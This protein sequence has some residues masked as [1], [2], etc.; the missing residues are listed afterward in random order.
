MGMDNQSAVNHSG[1]SDVDVNITIDTT[2]LAYAYACYMHASGK[3]SDEEFDRM[4]RK[5]DKLLEKNK[6]ISS[7]D[8]VLES[9]KSK[10]KS[11]SFSRQSSRTKEEEDHFMFF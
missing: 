6:H 1:N 3:L 8:A 10:R 4:I 11:S 2:A 5:L 7:R 9:K